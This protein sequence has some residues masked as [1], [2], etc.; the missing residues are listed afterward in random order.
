[1]LRTPTSLCFTSPLTNL[2]YSILSCISSSA[3]ILIS[4]MWRKLDI[5]FTLEWMITNSLCKILTTFFFRSEFTPN[6]INFL[7][8][9]VWMYCKILTPNANKML[10]Y[11]FE[12]PNQFILSWYQSLKY[13]HHPYLLRYLPRSPFLPILNIQLL[14][15][16]F[17][18]I[19]VHILSFDK[20]SHE[21]KKSSFITYH[22]FNDKKYVKKKQ[23]ERHLPGY[24]Q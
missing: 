9:P 20:D 13:S 23:R 18:V 19:Y 14:Q 17:H 2:L 11:Y 15:C 3:L 1:M 21:G 7:L 4:S 6:L 22:T 16:Y 24:W 5:I 12:L 8:I 10:S